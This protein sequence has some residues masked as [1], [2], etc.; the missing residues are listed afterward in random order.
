MK[1]LNWGFES[2]FMAMVGGSSREGSPFLKRV[3][4]RVDDFFLSNHRWELSILR[5]G[6]GEWGQKRLKMGKHIK[7]Y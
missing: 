3:Q 1:D 6:M 7:T 4:L 5:H 2:L